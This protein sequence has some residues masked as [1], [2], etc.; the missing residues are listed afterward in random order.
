[1]LDKVVAQL[2]KGTVKNVVPYGSTLPAAPYIVVKEEPDSGRNLTRYR[3]FYHALPGQVLPMRDYV[4]YDLVKLLDGKKLT[5]RSGN[6]NIVET[7][8]IIG[9]VVMNND[10]GTISQERAFYIC[11]L[12]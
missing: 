12:F 4:R 9:P 5:G 2:K 10:D 1:M 7:A 8:G 6:V 3:V 11:D